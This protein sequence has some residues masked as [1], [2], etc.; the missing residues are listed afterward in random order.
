MYL[1]KGYCE[2][3]IWQDISIVTLFKRQTSFYHL[4]IYTLSSSSC[5]DH[6]QP[7][8]S[9][10]WPICSLWSSSQPSCQGSGGLCIPENQHPEHAN[11]L[12]IISML[13]MMMRMVMRR[14]GKMATTRRLWHCVKRVKK[15]SIGWKDEQARESSGDAQAQEHTRKSTKNEQKVQFSI[16]G[17]RTQTQNWK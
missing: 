1:S 5:N 8:L 17:N 2:K 15:Y 16:S 9:R 12:K 10:I 4:K 6:H 13:L 3:S 14:W 7:T 11:M